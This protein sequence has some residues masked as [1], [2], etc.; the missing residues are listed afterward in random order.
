MQEFFRSFVAGGRKPSMTRFFMFPAGTDLSW[1][2]TVSASGGAP[3]QQ[4]LSS[5]CNGS[6]T[7]FTLTPTPSAP[8]TVMIVYNGQAMTNGADYSVSVAT[9]TMTFAP[10]TGD[11][12]IAWIWS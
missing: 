4:D 2:D 5:L 8:E 7:V 11:K 6:R 12:L 1:I 9:L 3:T 10:G